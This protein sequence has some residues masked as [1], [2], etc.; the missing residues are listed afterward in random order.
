MPT[1]K[2]MPSVKPSLAKLAVIDKGTEQLLQ[3]EYVVHNELT[4][5]RNQTNTIVLE[6][7]FASSEHACIRREHQGYV[8]TDLNSTNGVFVNGTKIQAEWMLS[9]GDEI[10]I[11]T[12]TFRFER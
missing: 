6:D 10:R 1:E 11:G 4:I 2:N 12:V 8:L 9:P 7:A 3:T 5:G